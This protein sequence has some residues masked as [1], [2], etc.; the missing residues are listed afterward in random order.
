MAVPTFP[1]RSEIKAGS[2]LVAVD[3]DG[4]TTYRYEPTQF[5]PTPVWDQKQGYSHD[6]REQITLESVGSPVFGEFNVTTEIRSPIDRVFEYVGDVRTLPEYADF[7]SRLD[8]VS[9]ETRGEDVVFEQYR[10][11]SDEPI[12]TEFLTYVPNEELEWVTH[13]R[14]GDIRVGYWFEPT[15]TGTRVYHAGVC[16]LADTSPSAFSSDLRALI[17]RYESNEAEMTTLRSI[18]EDR[19]DV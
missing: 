13:K 3:A 2:S 8:I 10:P 4:A 5:S 12:L 7:V 6:E 17:D 15:E 11:G 18:L 16:A 14:D 9:E 19:S 1:N